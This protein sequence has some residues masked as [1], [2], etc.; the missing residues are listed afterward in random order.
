MLSK[1][2][3]KMRVIPWYKMYDFVKSQLPEKETELVSN[4]LFA[5]TEF[6]QWGAGSDIISKWADPD[7]YVYLFDTTL[8]NWGRPLKPQDTRTFGQ[9]KESMDNYM[10]NQFREAGFDVCLPCEE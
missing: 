3:R 8:L 9:I 1:V 6:D 10:D 2:V 7:G 5:P 4:Y